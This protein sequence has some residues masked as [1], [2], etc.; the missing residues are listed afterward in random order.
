MMA[1]SRCSMSSIR[2]PHM[3]IQPLLETVAGRLA[4][5]L[6][7]ELRRRSYY[8]PLP[9]ADKLPESLWSGPRPTPGVNLRVAESLD[10]L[11]AIARHMPM[12]PAEF[13]IPNSSYEWGDAHTLWGMLRHLKPK[14]LIELG[15]GASSHVIRAAKEANELEGSGLEFESYDP[16]PGWHAMG[17][18]PDT[19]VHPIAAE[20]LDP[21]VVD[22]LNCGDVLFVDTTHTVRTGGDVTHIFLQLLPRLRSGV[23]VHIHDIFL[24]EEYPQH[25]VKQLRRAWAEQY[26]LQAF[27]AFNYEFEV[28]LPVHALWR[29]HH[30]EVVAAIPAAAAMRGDG[31][32][33]FWIKRR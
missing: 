22:S 23:Y 9:D 25:W 13:P 16:F 29:Y 24:P 3:N 6:G 32:A 18:A 4:R 30:D 19:L 31:P 28:I 33:A 14:R 15:S 8:L 2:L 20:T 26:L 12:F 5:R 27:L 10:M 11:G 17:V 1:D 7:Y 21:S